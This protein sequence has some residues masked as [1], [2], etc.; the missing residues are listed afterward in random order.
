MLILHRHVKLLLVTGIYFRFF[1]SFVTDK[2]VAEYTL[3]KDKK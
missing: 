3:E 1:F 2:K